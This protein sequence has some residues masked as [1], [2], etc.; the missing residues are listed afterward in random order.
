MKAKI[1]AYALLALIITTIH[2][3]EAQQPTKIP[4]IGYVSSGFRS[5]R[6]LKVFRPVLRDLGYIEGKNI[7]IEDRYL[8]G[9]WGRTRSIVA[10]LVQLRVDVLLSS[11]YPVTLAAKQLTSTI[12]IVMVTTQDPVATGIIDSLA[13]PGGI[14]RGSPCLPAS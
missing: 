6:Q 5:G 4:R 2:L 1:V 9:N 14:S 11:A 3:A 13:R 8:E 7:L 10:E 12:P